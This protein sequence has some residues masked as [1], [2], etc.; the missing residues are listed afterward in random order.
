MKLFDGFRA[1]KKNTA[2]ESD[3]VLEPNAFPDTVMEDWSSVA[4]QTSQRLASR[5][6]EVKAAEQLLHAEEQLLAGQRARLIELTHEVDQVRSRVHTRERE[7]ER[8]HEQRRELRSKCRVVLAEVD[9]LRLQSQPEEIVLP[10]SPTTSLPWRT[11]L[12]TLILGLTV[13]GAAAYWLPGQIV[14]SAA[15][16]GISNPAV[17]GLYDSIPAASGD[18]ADGMQISDRLTAESEKKPK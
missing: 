2:P 11:M 6:A 18:L 3:D 16:K 5:Q 1:A 15:A 9:Q 13:G 10:P 8:L 14:N 4:V 17:A 7:L 12:V